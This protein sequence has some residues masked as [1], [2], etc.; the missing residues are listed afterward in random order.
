MGAELWSCVGGI[1]TGDRS[2]FQGGNHVS[3]P[4][5]DRDPRAEDGAGCGPQ[6]RVSPLD[7]AVVLVDEVPGLAQQLLSR[8]RGLGGPALQFPWKY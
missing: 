5:Q 6:G 4:H 3:R 7:G 2:G 8:W 1:R